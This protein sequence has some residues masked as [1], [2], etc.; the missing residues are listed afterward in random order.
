MFE[1][2]FLLRPILPMAIH[3]N[4]MT[5]LGGAYSQVYNVKSSHI[6]HRHCLRQG[7]SLMGS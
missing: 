6:A 5:T 3:A 1:I 7:L 2:P 4:S